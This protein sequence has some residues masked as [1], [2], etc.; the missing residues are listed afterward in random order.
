MLTHLD[1]LSYGVDGLRGAFIDR[2]HFGVRPTS[3]SS[4]RL[5]AC[6]LALGARAF[7]RIQA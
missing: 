5:A 2:S 7:S 3:R 6:F 1:P 4:S